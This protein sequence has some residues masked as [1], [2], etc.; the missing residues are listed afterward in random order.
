MDAKATEYG[1]NALA[2]VK[3]QRA[4][5]LQ[6][7]ALCDMVERILDSSPVNQMLLIEVRYGYTQYDFNQ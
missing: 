2:E 5:N 7:D 4:M 6:Q 3:K 1:S